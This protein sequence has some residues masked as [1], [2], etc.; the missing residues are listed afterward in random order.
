MP[1]GASRMVPFSPSS[2]QRALE[3]GLERLT[4]A[5]GD[6]FVAGD[7]DD[8]H[9]KPFQQDGI[10]RI[11]SALPVVL[12]PFWILP[13]SLS[14]PWTNNCKRWNMPRNTAI[15]LAIQ[16]GPK[17][18]VALLIMAAGFYVGRWVGRLADSMLAKI[19]LD[20]HAA[21]V[22]GTHRARPGAGL[23][24]HHGAA[25]PG[26]GIAAA[27]GRTGSGGR[28]HRAG[29]AGRAGQSGGRADDH[30][31]PAVPGGRIHLHCR[32]GRHGRGIHL[33]NTMLSHPD[34]SRIVI[35]NR[36]I[37]GE[38]LHNF[39]SLRQ[40]DVVVGVAYD[41]DIKLALAAIRDLLAAHPKI[42]QEPEPMIRVLTLS[43]SS[44]NI[45]IRPWTTVDDYYDTSSEITQAVLET[46]RERGIRIPFPQR[47]VRL[48]ERS[49][50]A[51]NPPL[52]P[53]KTTYVDPLAEVLRPGQSIELLKELHILTR[54]GKLNQDSR[55]KLKQVYHLCQFIEPLL[56]EVLSQ[57]DTLTLA[58]HGAGKSYLG[59]ILYDLFLKDRP[60]AHIYGIETRDELVEKSRE[61]AAR[62]GFTRMSF[63]NETV[64][65]SITAE[66]PAR[67]AS[68][69]SPRCMPAIPQPTMPSSSPSPSR[70]A[71]SCWC[72]AARPRLR[73]CCANT[74]TNPSAKP[75]C[76]KSGATR[77]T[78]ANSA[79]SSPTCCAACNWNRTA[80][81]LPSPNWSAGNTR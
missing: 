30:F 62:L 34:H 3:I 67:R 52:P 75:R 48:L 15:D 44:V 31:H 29:D 35:P 17:L 26:R 71:T 12:I 45:A 65:E 42:L 66:H 63:L 79:A 1:S 25:E 19:G 49:H 68:I 74:R 78:P 50:E 76:P 28:G 54:D 60:G 40:L 55:R 36:K 2:T 69:S 33:F 80:T 57:Q 61:L 22:A 41:T 73:R 13:S 70:P 53:S 51:A 20:E 9:G 10:I 46:F 8:R 37:V 72:P 38:I 64:A 7:I 16:F 39:G 56:D 77:S 58:D 59:F 81:R 47:E 27:A 11:G 6:K 23:V 24:P 4:I 18:L 43:D 14:R 32:R 5:Q 21:P